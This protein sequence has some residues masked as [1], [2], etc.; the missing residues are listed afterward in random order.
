[1][2]KLNIFTIYIPKV[3]QKKKKAWLIAYLFISDIL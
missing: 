3:D 2:L 1:M